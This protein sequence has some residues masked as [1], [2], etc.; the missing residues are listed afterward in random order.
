[1]VIGAVNGQRC[2]RQNGCRCNGHSEATVD[3]QRPCV[4]EAPERLTCLAFGC[5]GF[6][7]HCVRMTAVSDGLLIAL[8]CCCCLGIS[9]FAAAAASAAASAAAAAA[10]CASLIL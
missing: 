9:S 10:S 5:L 4:L 2:P 8:D 6:S 1:M 7:G 3:H